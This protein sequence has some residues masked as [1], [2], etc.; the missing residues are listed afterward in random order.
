MA[1][2]TYNVQP[3][4]GQFVVFET[5]Y[6]GSVALGRFDTKEDADLFV[7][8]VTMDVATLEQIMAN[9]KKEG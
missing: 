8:Q 7:S 2:P 1:K 4:E 3:D 6:R 5:D 9:P